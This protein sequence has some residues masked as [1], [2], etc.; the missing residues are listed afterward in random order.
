M[1][2]NEFVNRLLNRSLRTLN[3]LAVAIGKSSLNDSAAAIRRIV[4]AIEEVAAV[5]TMVY[6]QSPD[7]LYHYE[8]NRPPTR[9]MREIASLITQAGE[10]ES[11]GMTGAAIEKLSAAIAMEPPALT[12]EMLTK[13]LKH[14]KG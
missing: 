2:K 6:E 10:L 5:Q 12:H 4:A 3:E 11:A 1:D 14:L 7:L 13:K 8:E 9:F